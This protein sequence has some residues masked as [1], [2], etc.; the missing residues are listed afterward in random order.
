MQFMFARL[1]LSQETVT[2][3][4]K[5]KIYQKARVKLKNTKINIKTKELRKIFNIKI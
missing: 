2:V 1:K 4:Q 3:L 5:V